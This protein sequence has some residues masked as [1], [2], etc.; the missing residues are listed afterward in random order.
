MKKF[1]FPLLAAFALTVGTAAAQTTTPN[2]ASA[3]QGRGRQQGSPDEMAKRQADRMT[4]ELGL[5]THQTGK[6]QQI[7][8]ARG[9][10]M[11][12][13]R[14]QDRDA[15]NRDQMREQ[16]Q[17]GRAKYDAQFKE[18]LTAE[19]YT[20]YTT[21][22]ADRMNRGGGPGMGGSDV[23]KMKAKSTDGDKIKVKTD[24]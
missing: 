21:M 5:N 11:Q 16:M 24:K 2:D 23:K 3:M 6:V 19:Q 10:E 15:D 13:M 12:T 14:G 4:K 8:L 17:A 1:L 22:Q 18:V 9:Q 7:M 20:K